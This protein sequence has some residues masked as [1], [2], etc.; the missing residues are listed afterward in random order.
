[1]AK[2]SKLESGF[3][4][5]YDWLPAIENLPAKEVKA[6]LLAL[7]ARQRENKPLPL[8]H[9]ALTASY[10]RMIEPSIKRRLDGAVGKK[11]AQKLA[12]QEDDGGEDGWGDGGVPPLPPK[13]SRDKQKRAE[14]SKEKKKKTN[15]L[16][17]V[18]TTRG[19]NAPERGVIARAC[20]AGGGV[21]GHAEREKMNS[22]PEGRRPSPRGKKGVKK[23][24]DTKSSFDVDDFFEAALAKAYEGQSFG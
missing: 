10:A 12:R 18:A 2:N 1:M 20:D 22:F 17:S 3:L 16:F 8:F 11:A 4:F 14:K 24:A 13:Q 23:S 6:L 7:I 21:A 9:N 5:L 15:S 19:D